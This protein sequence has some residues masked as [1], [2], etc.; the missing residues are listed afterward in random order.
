LLKSARAL[1]V[2]TGVAF[3]GHAG[4]PV[5]FPAEYRKW[6]VARSLVVGTENQNF[7]VNGGFH[8][9]LANTRARLHQ[10]YGDAASLRVENGERGVV[11]TMTL[12]YRATSDISENQHPYV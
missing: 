6:A 12:P 9:Y 1:L 5:P 3:A 11:A 10:L 4:G 7:A 8:H 2:V